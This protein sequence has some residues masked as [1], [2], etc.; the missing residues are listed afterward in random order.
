MEVTSPKDFF[1]KAL[2]ERFNPDEAEGVDVTVQITITG[3]NGGDWIVT[4]K[5][6][7]LDVKEGVH[8]SP[9]LSL[10]MAEKDYLDLINKKISAE[11]AFFTGKVQFKGNIALALKLKEAGFL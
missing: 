7:N 8:E 5:N 9:N 2:P 3:E 10:K 11:K 6:Q 1:E 4:I